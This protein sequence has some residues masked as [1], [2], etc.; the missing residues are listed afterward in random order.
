MPTPTGITLSTDDV[1]ITVATGLGISGNTPTSTTGT[2]EAIGATVTEWAVA[3]VVLFSF[4]S[5]RSLYFTD[6]DSN[7]F[8][9]CNKSDIRLKY[10]AV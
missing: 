2:I 3:D 6:A 7:T 9:I 1:A 4:E 5:G 8:A 10:V